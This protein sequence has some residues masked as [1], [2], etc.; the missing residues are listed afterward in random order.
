MTACSISPDD[1]QQIPCNKKIKLIHTPEQALISSISIQIV[2]VS[3]K[4]TSLNNNKLGT[5]SWHLSKI[6][7]V[8]VHLIFSLFHS[9][10][11]EMLASRLPYACSQI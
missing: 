8:H 3:M 4:D 7:A 6:K 11:V 9:L 5:L 10:K 1:Y 2:P